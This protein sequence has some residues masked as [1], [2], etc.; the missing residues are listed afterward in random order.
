MAAIK[1]QVAGLSNSLDPNHTMVGTDEYCLIWHYVTLGDWLHL[2]S[3][4]DIGHGCGRLGDKVLLWSADAKTL[5][6][7]R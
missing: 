7:V 6:D 5:S 3:W 2:L 1:G 4:F